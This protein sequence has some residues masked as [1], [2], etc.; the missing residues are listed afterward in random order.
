MTLINKHTDLNKVIDHFQVY[1]IDDLM[2]E[3]YEDNQN[4][5]S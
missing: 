4:E 3:L 2:L 5:Y 1:V